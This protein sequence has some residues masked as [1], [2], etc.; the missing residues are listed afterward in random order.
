VIATLKQLRRPDD[1][2]TA[3]ADES[4]RS[5]ERL[6]RAGMSAVTGA[7]ARLVSVTVLF[8]LVPIVGRHLG[9][10]GGGVWLLLVTGT[11][12]LGF[13]DLGLGNGLVNVLSQ[14]KGQDDEDLAAAATSSAFFSLLLVGLGFAAT[15]VALVPRIDWASLLNVH[16]PAADQTAAAVGVFVGSVVV[17]MPLALG[18]R[19]HHASQEGWAAAITVVGGALLSLLGVLIAASMG[20]GLVGFVLGMVAGPPI[21]YG[22]ESALVYLHRHPH[23]RPRVALATWALAG[24]VARSGFLFFVLALSI[25]VAYESDAIVI[26]HFLGSQ[27]VARY[28]LALRLFMLAPAAVG[29]LVMPLWPAYGEALTRGDVSWAHRTLRRSLRLAVALAIPPSLLLLVLTGPVLVAWAGESFQPS[30]S[31]LLGLACWAVVSA[32]SMALAVFFNGAD[33]I[34]FQVWLALAMAFSNI[35]LSI[36]LV[37]TIG[38]A[39]PVWASALTQTVVVLVPE[40]LLVRRILRDGRPLSGWVSRIVGHI[41][42]HTTSVGATT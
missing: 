12:L 28:T 1:P 38:I 16:G 4:G 3:T 40:L 8:L 31:L 17:S 30:A 18:Q 26:S 23:L 2:A 39:G 34:R 6:R 32:V 21:A 24:R 35:V 33:V 11:A 15:A 7:A 5:R 29:I 19:I 37:Q 25:A 20:A 9:A 10:E 42:S 41:P 27:D 14:A 13:A 36:V 22:V